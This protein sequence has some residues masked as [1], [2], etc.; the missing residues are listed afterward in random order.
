VRLAVQTLG[1]RGDVQPYLALACG[2][3]AAG[4][5]AVLA[6]AAR[7]ES[8]VATNGI[9]FAPLPDG[10]LDLMDAP[11]GKAALSGRNTVTWTLRLVREVRPMMRRLLDAQWATAQGQKR[12]STIPRPLAAF[13]LP[14]GWISRRSLPSPCPE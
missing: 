3:K 14:S 9:S 7:F 2:L 5:E 1:T 13:T 8:F 11:A 4:Y 6:T 12:S 10:F